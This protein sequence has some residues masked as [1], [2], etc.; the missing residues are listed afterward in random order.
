M[1]VEALQGSILLDTNVL[2]YSTLLRDSRCERA[3]EI[4]ELRKKEG[5]DVHI[6]VQNLSEMYPNLTGPKNQPP[7]SPGLARRKIESI[8]ELSGL[9]IKEPSCD[10]MRLA[11]ELCERYD[12]RRQRFFD[13]QLAALMLQEKIGW[14]VTENAR[15]FSGIEGLQAW[16]PFK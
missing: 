14:I 5:L 13:M 8:A 9:I 6:S 2:I 12:V 7:D 3:R 1:N 15:D 16:N 10:T 11:L 4:L